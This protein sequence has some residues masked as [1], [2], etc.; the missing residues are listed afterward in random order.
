MTQLHFAILI[1]VLFMSATFSTLGWSSGRSFRQWTGMVLLCLTFC[2]SV[3][4]GCVYALSTVS[5]TL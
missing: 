4:L 1:E 2:W 5:F 3:I